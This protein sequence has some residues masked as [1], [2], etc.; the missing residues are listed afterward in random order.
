[1]APDTATTL[2]PMTLPRHL[3]PVPT[4]TARERHGFDF[5]QAL[6]RQ[7]DPDL[8]FPDSYHSQQAQRAKEVC[9]RCTV[10][11]AC[12]AYAMKLNIDEGVFGGFTA[13]ERAK[14]KRM[15]AW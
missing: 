11:S 1:M 6:C 15:G 2:A 12:L 7:I 13:P 5:D 4:P 8:F 3:E 14:I 9:A 10:R